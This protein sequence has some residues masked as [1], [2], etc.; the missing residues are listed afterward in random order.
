MKKANRTKLCL[1]FTLCLA[2][3]FIL[4]LCIGKFNIK[5]DELLKLEGMSSRVFFTLRLPRVIVAVFGGFALGVAG[6]VF[7]TV[8]HNPLA[9]PDMIGVSSGASAGAAAAILFA[10]GTFISVTLASFIGGLTA[11]AITIGLSAITKKNGSATI[12][13]AG[14]AVH[15]VAQTILMLLKSVADPEK[16]LAAIEYWIMGGLGGVSLS[17]C[18]P[19]V[20]LS[21]LSIIP[22]FLLNRQIFILSTEEDDAKMLG[23]S[24]AKMRLVALLLSTLAVTA[25]VSLTGIISFVGLLA[26]HAARLLLKSNKT[27]TL[28]LSGILGA[29]LLTTADILARSVF[30]SELPVSIFTSAIGAPFLIYLIVRRKQSL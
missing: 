23:V 10:S 12:V 26:P 9:A 21:I 1:L 27:S 15:S 29:V 24:V 19:S 7:Q 22:L 4:S 13:L 14:I 20:I 18:L 28:Y 11:V 6:S 25:T 17:N 3:V 2:F 30:Q 8:F 16:E 5:L